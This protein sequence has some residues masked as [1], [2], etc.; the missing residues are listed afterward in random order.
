MSALALHFYDRATALGRLAFWTGDTA[1]PDDLPI[2]S[3]STRAELR[4]WLEAHHDSH[5]GLWVR[6]FK[7]A[8]DKPSVSFE[9]VLDEGLCFG[10]SES[11]RRSG[12]ADSYLQKFAPRKTRGTV[13]AR[14]KAHATKLIADGQ[15][16]P[17]GLQALGME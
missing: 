9:D 3:F 4:T 12:D 17:A 1:M 8:S 15:M 5:K 10:W 11:T 2:K 14:N 6:I 16:T 13:S 7:A